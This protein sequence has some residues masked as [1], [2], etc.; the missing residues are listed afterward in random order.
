MLVENDEKQFSKIIKVSSP[1]KNCTHSCFWMGWALYFPT[2]SYRE[3]NFIKG[4]KTFL[5]LNVS[6]CT[7]SH[8]FICVDYNSV[9]VESLS[10]LDIP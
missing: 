9:E 3:R 8:L 4:Q 5:S 1:Y 6:K 10:H 7:I 2:K